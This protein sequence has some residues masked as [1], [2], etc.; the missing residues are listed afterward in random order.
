M[1]IPSDSNTNLLSAPFLHTSFSY[2]SFSIAAS[3][4]WNSISP[5]LYQS[6]Y[7]SSSPQDPLLPASLPIHLTPLLL[8]LIFGLAGQLC[9]FI[10]YIYLLCTIKQWYNSERANTYKKLLIR[11]P[12]VIPKANSH[13]LFEVCQN[14]NYSFNFRHIFYPAM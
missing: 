8:C 3:K 9:T 1:V 11:A 14:V 12:T 2:R 10:N 7:L 5:Y 6:W 4:I 13:V